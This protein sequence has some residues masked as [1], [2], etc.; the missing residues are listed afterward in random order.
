M[1]SSFGELVLVLGDFHV[2]E[3]ASKIPA[4]FKRML[5]PNRMQHVVCTGNVGS[6]M[7]LWNEI[8]QLAPSFH[9]V[10]GDVDDDPNAYPETCVFQ[11]GQFRIGAIHGHQLL[12][13]GS[14]ES[15]EHMRRKL[16]VDILV[17]GHTHQSAVLD[18]NDGFYHI[19]PVR[20]F[21][22]FFRV[23]RCTQLSLSHYDVSSGNFFQGS[24][25][26]A[27]SSY[28]ENIT[29]SFILLAVQE[30]KVVC[31]V[32]ELI[33]GEVE[34]SK[35]EFMKANVSD[36]VASNSTLLDTLLK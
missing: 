31:Y 15:V 32:Y 34:V 9:C 17:T 33:N 36:R 26:G 28:S 6:S 29:P 27:L 22:I 7:E 2:P 4:P 11:V 30:A 1:S 16:R 3:R 5:I 20:C 13:W 10:A 12:P 21:L 25:T 24:I 18:E 19:N 8:R 14:K 35:T 23:V